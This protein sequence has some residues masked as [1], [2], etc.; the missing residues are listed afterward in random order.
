MM[1]APVSVFPLYILQT[2]ELATKTNRV[3]VLRILPHWCKMSR[4]YLVPVPDN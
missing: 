4:S 1:M 3:L 2:E